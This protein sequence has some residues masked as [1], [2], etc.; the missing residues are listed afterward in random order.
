MDLLNEILKADLPVHRISQTNTAIKI[1]T[2]EE[3]VA[4][5]ANNTIV[6]DA[7]ASRNNIRELLVHG[8]IAVTNLMTMAQTTSAPAVYQVLATL[9]KT[10][11]ELNH[12]LMEVHATEQALT[13]N[14]PPEVHNHI[15]KAI[16][17]GS[18]A[19]LAEVMKQKKAQAD[20]NC[21]ESIQKENQKIQ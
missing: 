17:V 6:E 18:T 9:L 11:S 21:S 1:V 8:K 10:V 13:E 2:P 7:I 3:Q 12:D 20:V 15:D 14:D 4:P 5:L 19:E 16:F